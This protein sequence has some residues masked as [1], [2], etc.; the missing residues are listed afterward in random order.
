MTEFLIIGTLAFI[1]WAI[2]RARMRRRSP[3]AIRREKT[4]NDY[5]PDPMA[6]L[7]VKANDRSIVGQPVEVEPVRFL[8]QTS[9]VSS[10][11]VRKPEPDDYQFE[12]EYVD[13]NGKATERRIAWVHHEPDGDDTI[14]H[15]YC[16]LAQADRK[17][18]SSR[19][20]SCK[21]LWTGRQIKDL[22]RYFRSGSYCR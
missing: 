1:G 17:F 7:D 12:I 15:A 18:R 11:E 2:Y 9:I 14:L 10:A 20:Q 8:V 3:D 21:N 13:R 22:G 6:H 19:I 5:R 16:E 4:G